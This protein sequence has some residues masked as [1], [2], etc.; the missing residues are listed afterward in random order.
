V[1]VVRHKILGSNL[2]VRCVEIADGISVSGPE[3]NLSPEPEGSEQLRF[4]SASLEISGCEIGRSPVSVFFCPVLPWAPSYLGQLFNFHSRNKSA[5]ECLITFLVLESSS[6]TNSPTKQSP[7]SQIVVII[8]DDPSASMA[9][10]EQVTFCE[11]VSTSCSMFLTHFMQ[12]LLI[13][14][15]SHANWDRQQPT[16]RKYPDKEE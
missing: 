16:M 1:I 9:F 13:G 3:Q 15:T 12:V 2:R 14:S 5:Y 6:P 11:H 8:F 10:A 4:L 7:R